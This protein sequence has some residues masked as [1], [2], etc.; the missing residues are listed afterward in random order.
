MHRLTTKHMSIVRDSAYFWHSIY[1]PLS[2]MLCTWNL[3]C[4]C[5]ST[6]QFPF[7]NSWILP[8]S[9]YTLL[10]STVA[11]RVSDRISACFHSFL[12]I[13]QVSLPFIARESW[14]LIPWVHT[15]LSVSFSRGCRW[16][17]K[18]IALFCLDWTNLFKITFP[19]FVREYM[20]IRL[21]ISPMHPLNSLL[22][23]VTFPLWERLQTSKAL[24]FIQIRNW[25]YCMAFL[26]RTP[27]SVSV[28][29][30]EFYYW[31]VSVLGKLCTAIF[32]SII[33]HYV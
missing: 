31:S 5:Y 7:P 23:S 21:D 26:F 14:F 10:L 30:I 17:E 6:N 20:M 1:G 12:L 13:F 3:N 28:S 33:S 24:W 11:W 16:E 4:F 2:L 22:F 32:A 18:L 29:M 25:Y 8:S 27:Q 15:L 9:T 19:I